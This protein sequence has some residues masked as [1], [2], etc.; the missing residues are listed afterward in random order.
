MIKW[1]LTQSWTP[2]TTK[3]R[4]CWDR[5]MSRCKDSLNWINC[6]WIMHLL[7]GRLLECPSKRFSSKGKRLWVLQ[8]RIRDRSSN[9]SSCLGQALYRLPTTSSPPKRIRTLRLQT[10]KMLYQVTNKR[11]INPQGGKRI[12]NRWSYVPS[13]FNTKSMSFSYRVKTKIPT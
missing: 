2:S 8:K 13:K 4:T 3:V 5:M 1:N 9:K 7:P 6:K 11:P 10:H 12:W